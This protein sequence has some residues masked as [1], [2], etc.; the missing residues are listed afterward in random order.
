MSNTIN[1]LL[2]KWRNYSSNLRPTDQDCAD[3]ID[4][5]ANTRDVEPR[6]WAEARSL[7][8][9]HSGLQ[10]KQ[11]NQEISNARLKSYFGFM[12]YTVRERVMGFLDRQKYEIG[13]NG[14]FY[15]PQGDQPRAIDRDA[16]Y[17]SNEI[18]EVFTDLG[19]R[20]EP[21][22]YVL[23]NLPVET[24]SRMMRSKFA[25]L[26]FNAAID[27]DFDE[28]FKFID[29][30]VGHNGDQ[31]I[32][33]A[34]FTA[35][36]SFVYRVKNMLRGDWTKSGGW[37]IIPILFGA[38]GDGKSKA[39]KYFMSVLDEMSASLNLRQLEDNSTAFQLS[40]MPV[41]VLE[42]TAGADKADKDNF[43]AIVTDETR[44]MRQAYPLRPTFGRREG[45]VGRAGMGRGRR[46]A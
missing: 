14:K 8:A 21:N 15:Q 33:S 46:H 32:R 37:Q 1:A 27:P 18:N 41:M 3:F 17:I 19:L 11:A 20:T 28:M 36:W 29:L 30:I 44:I 34:A 9:Q 6:E 7:F 13:F 35:L 23:D 16:D 22:R 10:T 39:T 38:Q 31:D 5:L 26:R 42:E 25:D 43:K 12:P 40:I 4:T 2:E 24:R 45:E